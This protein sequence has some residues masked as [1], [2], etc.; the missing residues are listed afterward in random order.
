MEKNFLERNISPKMC[1]F[2]K[3][4]WNALIFYIPFV[5]YYI[6]TQGVFSTLYNLIFTPVLLSPSDL[7][8]KRNSNASNH[9]WDA[10]YFSG[11]KKCFQ[12]YGSK[13]QHF[14]NKKITNILTSTILKK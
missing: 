7:S 2:I 9:F 5:S 11:F 6:F 8:E 4:N 14:I 1:S 10:L 12:K 3:D 13:A